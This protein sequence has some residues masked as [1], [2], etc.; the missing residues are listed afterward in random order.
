M[1]LDWNA[2]GDT[3]NPYFGGWQIYRVT[4]PITAST[5]FPDPDDTPANSFGMD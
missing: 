4:S 1:R 2:T 5:Y 3:D